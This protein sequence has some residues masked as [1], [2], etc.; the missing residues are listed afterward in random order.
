METLVVIKTNI[1]VY[2]IL[3][4]FGCAERVQME[5]ICL[6]MAEEVFHAGIVQAIPFLDILVLCIFV[7]WCC[8]DGMYTGTPDHYIGGV[9][10]HSVFLWSFLAYH[11]FFD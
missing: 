4:L 10:L 11:H 2:G 8:I 6:E 3:Y 7:A 5:T 1:F 9:H